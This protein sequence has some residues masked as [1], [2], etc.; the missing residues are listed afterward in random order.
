LVI[1]YRSRASLAGGILTGL[2][3]RVGDVFLLSLFGLTFYSSGSHITWA[4]YLLIIISFTKSAQAPFSSWLP[5]AILAPTP[6]S[7]LVHSSTLVTAGVFLLFRYYPIGSSLLL[8][9][10]IF[11]TLMAGLAAALECDVKKI[12]ALSTLSQLGLMITS[13]GLGARSLCFAHLNTHAAFK[14]LLFL[15]IGTYIHSIYGSQEARSVVILPSTSP[16]TMVVLVTARLSMCG[17]VFLSGWATKE[18]ILEARF[19]AVVSAC[20]L[21]LLY[22]GIGL[23]LSYSLR[24]SNLLFLSCYHTSVMA[25]AFSIPLAVKV[26]MFWL[27]RQSLIQGYFIRI[28]FLGQPTMLC[29]FDKFLVWGVAIVSI[30][31]SV[32]HRFNNV[33]I[34]SPALNL[35]ATTT[36]HSRLAGPISRLRFTE[37][38][39]LQG[40]GLACMPS[41]L[42]PFSPGTHFFTKLSL[43]LSFSFIL[44]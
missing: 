44:L 12:I 39:E 2:T 18:A 5:A 6:V 33:N 20:S 27:Y 25:P 19:N 28:F 23:T 10:G 8:F 24:L 34:Q 32:S 40:G 4:L 13:L 17:L 3:N 1:F 38:R 37:V 26:P 31:L 7:A 36:L 43:V 22:V 35:C 15:A 9:V 11:T 21:T 14:A 16:L 30:S 29:Y 42:T 41:L